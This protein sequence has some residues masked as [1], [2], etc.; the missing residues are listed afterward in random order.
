[1]TP[2]SLCSRWPIRWYRRFLPRRFVFKPFLYN[3]HTV[4]AHSDPPP[5]RPRCRRRHAVSHPQDLREECLKLRTRVFDLEQQNR[6]LS[7]L[8]QQKIKPASDLLIQVTP[9]THRVSEETHLN[10]CR[11][12]LNTLH[13]SSKTARNPQQAAT[14]STHD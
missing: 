13:A 5:P 10:A 9:P 11:E 7:V 6:A 2:F 12:T 1:M 14:L 4:R 3:L 8:F